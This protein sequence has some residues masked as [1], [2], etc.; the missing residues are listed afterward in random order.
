MVE[1]CEEQ[2]K[3]CLHGLSPAS[4]RSLSHACL[5]S[6]VSALHPVFEERRD[7]LVTNSSLGLTGL[8]CALLGSRPRLT[9]GVTSVLP[10]FREVGRCLLCATKL[11]ETLG[12][13]GRDTS[14][15]ILD[16]MPAIAHFSSLGSAFLDR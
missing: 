7:L 2:N 6:N 10:L 11:R 3:G 1:V 9:L 12:K 16:Q 4:N 13:Q 14:G 5:G 15:K 8:L